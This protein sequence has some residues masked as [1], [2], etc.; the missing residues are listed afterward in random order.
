MASRVSPSDVGAPDALGG[1]PPSGEADAGRLT[2]LP[3]LLGVALVLIGAGLTFVASAFDRGAAARV[4]GDTAPVNAGA[5][6]E[7]DINAHNSPALVASRPSCRYFS[8][9]CCDVPRTR[10]SGP[11]LSKT[12][13]RLSG[14]LP[15]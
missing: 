12:W 6:A 8:N 2:T 11:I 14:T 13:F 4:A 3:A 10:R 15:L 9:S 7:A 5:R 1:D